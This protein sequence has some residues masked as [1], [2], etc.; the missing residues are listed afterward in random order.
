MLGRAKRGLICWGLGFV[1]AWGSL[2]LEVDQ[3][4]TPFAVG[5]GNG[6]ALWGTFRS[7]ALAKVAGARNKGLPVRGNVQFSFEET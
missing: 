2:G 3:G 4:L 5:G 7:K 1:G 6:S